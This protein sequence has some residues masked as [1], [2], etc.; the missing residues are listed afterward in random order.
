MQVSL[1]KKSSC[2]GGSDC[3]CWFS[4]RKK[5]PAPPPPPVLKSASSVQDIEKPSP[6]VAS[7]EPQVVETPL[8]EEKPE[9]EVSGGNQGRS[10]FA[11]RMFKPFLEYRQLPILSPFRGKSTKQRATLALEQISQNSTLTLGQIYREEVSTVTFADSDSDSD[12]EIN[13][14]SC[15]CTLKNSRSLLNFDSQCFVDEQ[16]SFEDKLTAHAQSYQLKAPLHLS[17]MYDNRVGEFV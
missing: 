5:K 12:D 16:S 8:I 10:R 13:T 3:F 1:V 6:V 7:P 2:S 9:V 14:L 4:G 11:R 15:E 17:I